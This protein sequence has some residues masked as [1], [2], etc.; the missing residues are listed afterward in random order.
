[1]IRKAGEMLGEEGASF[2]ITGEVLGQRPMSQHKRALTTVAVESGHNGLILR[3]LSA[4]LL[5][6]TIPEKNGWVKREGL[7]GF[8]G[9]SRKPQMALAKKFGIQQYP[10]P[11]GGCLLTDEFFSRRLRD[12]FSSGEDV[13][14]RDIELLKL[15][16]H[17]RIGPHTKLIVGR[18][19]R[20]NE[21]ICSLTYENDIMLTT[22]PV[23]GP[24]VLVLGELTP[25]LEELAASITVSYSDAEENVPTEVHLIGKEMTKRRMALGRDKG[26]YRRYMIQGGITM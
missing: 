12:L 2:I 15:G 5:P 19:K 24:S 21:A 8:S 3:P 11:A 10:S 9:R 18:N 6:I 13:Q 22:L 26:E 4:L 23:P 16:R 1:M 25:E 17:L 7:M 14:A 20:E